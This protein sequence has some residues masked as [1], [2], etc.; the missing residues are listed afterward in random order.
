MP[1]NAQFHEKFKLLQIPG[2]KKKKITKL[3]PY[4]FS[5]KMDIFAFQNNPKNLDLSYKM[6]VDLRDCLVI[7][8]HSGDRI[9]WL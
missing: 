6:D 3:L 5:Y 8:S 9:S 4:F 2:S 7:C 1:Q